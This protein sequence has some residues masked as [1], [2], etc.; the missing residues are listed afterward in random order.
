MLRVSVPRADMAVGKGQ[1]LS[2]G[3]L[4]VLLAH[5]PPG[6]APAPSSTRVV[7]TGTGREQ[8][9]AEGRR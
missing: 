4:H 8:V 6:N 3:Q 5:E 7:N 9:L 2:R 1:S